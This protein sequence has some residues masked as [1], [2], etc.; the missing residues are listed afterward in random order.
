MLAG[1]GFTETQ[2]VTKTGIRADIVAIACM[3]ANHLLPGTM[4]ALI[5]EGWFDS[6]F[7][8]E[9]RAKISENNADLDEAYAEREAAQ[10]AYDA[11]PTPENEAKLE[12]AKAKYQHRLDVYFD[13]PH[14][15]DAGRVENKVDKA[16]E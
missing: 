4:D 12:A 3:P 2:I 6:I 5:A 10:A 16:M 14:E 15:F 8:E 7:S 13:M 11:N 9:G 1:K